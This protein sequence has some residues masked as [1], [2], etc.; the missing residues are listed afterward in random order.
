MLGS[1]G[2]TSTKPRSGILASAWDRAVA[3]FPASPRQ[4]RARYVRRHDLALTLCRPDLLPDISCPLVIRYPATSCWGSTHLRQ[5]FFRFRIFAGVWLGGNRLGQGAVR[6]A[7][8]FLPSSLPSC[9]KRTLNF[10][11]GQ[12]E[13]RDGD[14]RIAGVHEG[15]PGRHPPLF[16]WVKAACLLGN[17]GHRAVYLTSCRKCGVQGKACC[18]TS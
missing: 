5:P 1:K 9:L 15:H 4:T 2:P 12:K 14:V 10:L 8:S 11:D 13:T 16:R 3:T 18:E 6:K 17:Y 7:N